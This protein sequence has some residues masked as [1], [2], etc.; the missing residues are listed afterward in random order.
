MRLKRRFTSPDARATQGGSA[1]QPQE[2]ERTAT[3]EL[4]LYE[5][6]DR[7]RQLSPR[8]RT[9][10]PPPQSPRVQQR[11]H[12]AI[13]K[14]LDRMES[15]RRSASPQSPTRGLRVQEDAH[16]SLPGSAAYG[17]RHIAA[18][19]KDSGRMEGNL[20]G[21][22]PRR[23]M[24]P[25]REKPG[26]CLPQ[27]PRSAS[28]SD[29]RSHDLPNPIAYDGKGFIDTRATTI[30]ARQQ[31][32]AAVEHAD[33]VQEELMAFADRMASA[34]HVLEQVQ[35]ISRHQQW[36]ALFREFDK[37]GDGKIS[38][39]EWRQVLRNKLHLADELE[40]V[41]LMFDLFD[42]DA[43]GTL[44]VRE[45]RSNVGETHHAHIRQALARELAK[46]ARLQGA[47]PSFR[48]FP[49]AAASSGNKE[50]TTLEATLVPTLAAAD[51]LRPHQ[52][53]IGT[54][55]IDRHRFNEHGAA[56]CNHPALLEDHLLLLE[57]VAGADAGAARAAAGQAAGATGAARHA[58]LGGFYIACSE[59]AGRRWLL[60]V[61]VR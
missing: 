58:A 1:P 22:S 39:H 3:P 14:H 19:H 49:L 28:R 13:Q 29:T 27:S 32:N 8:R 2:I 45:F 44:D 6:A 34:L 51:Y 57:S 60:E 48:S 30:S 26:S 7:P 11:H 24:S 4:T 54:L 37:N 12:A 61:V 40:D 35:A 43:S 25:P 52:R 17:M 18:S 59:E 56:A 38:K 50:S 15:P 47:F 5:M 55:L 21:D 53:I 42:Q 31:H 16:G 20:R 23:G 9:A 10:S 41:D 36:P 46:R 33:K